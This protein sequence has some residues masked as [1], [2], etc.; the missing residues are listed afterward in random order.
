[1]EIKELTLF[2]PYPFQEGE[3]IRIS[4]GPRAG[5]WLVEKVSTHKITLKCPVSNREFSWDRFCYVTEILHKA[6]WPDPKG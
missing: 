4:D 6:Q 1:M 5:D 3:K 2:K